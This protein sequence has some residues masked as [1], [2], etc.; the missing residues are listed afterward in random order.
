MGNALE[1][2]RHIIYISGGVHRDAMASVAPR[3]TNAS[4]PYRRALWVEFPHEGVGAASLGPSG[5][6]RTAGDWQ[7]CGMPRHAFC[8]GRNGS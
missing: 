8:D 7:P 6:R 3:T 5:C 1:D 2:P 4:R